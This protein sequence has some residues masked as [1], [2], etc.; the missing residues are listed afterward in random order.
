MAD[1][2]TLFA[3][4]VAEH[5][6]GGEADPLLYL[7]QAQGP[8]RAELAALIDGYLV[9]APG[10]GWD[11]EAFKGSLAATWTEGMG[12]SLSG[13]AGIWP[14]LLPSLRERARIRRSELVERLAGALGVGA[15]EERVGSYYHQMEQGQLASEGVS[16]R[17]LEA[18]AGLVGSSADALREAGEALGP[19]GSPA[20]G[21]V[22]A[23]TAQPD[24]EWASADAMAPPLRSPGIDAGGSERRQPD[25]DEVDRLFTGG[26]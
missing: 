12:R 17:V 20:S 2:D 14:V 8:E 11:G 26:D 1:I 15:E 25:R 9:R 6:S 21:A 10:Q 19:G 5:R 22:F 24:S 7:E 23:R 4:Y 16:T 3:D 18:L 13:S